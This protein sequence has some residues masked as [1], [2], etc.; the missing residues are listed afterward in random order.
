M[1]QEEE[2]LQHIRLINGDEIIGE[3]EETDTGVIVHN[4]LTVEQMFSDDGTQRMVLMNYVPF[5]ETKSCEILRTQIITRGDVH[6]EI[7]RYY[8]YSL[9]IAWQYDYNMLLELEKV[10]NRMLENTSEK[11]EDDF[12]FTSNTIH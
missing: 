1:H 11:M 8:Y 12:S 4:P 7:K 2:H 5:S 9:K 10:N 3:T 6:S